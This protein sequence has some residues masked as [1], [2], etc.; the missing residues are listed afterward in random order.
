MANL[1]ALYQDPQFQALT[2]DKKSN[3]IVGIVG[4][5]PD[6]QKLP[7]DR[8][9]YVLNGIMAKGREQWTPKKAPEQESL[10]KNIAGSAATIADQA[11][12]LI[13]GGAQAAGQAFGWAKNALMG[14]P[15]AAQEA[16]AAVSPLD[17][18]QGGY[19]KLVDAALGPG[20]AANSTVGHFFG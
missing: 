3:V 1:S 19:S 8:K 14:K 10:G 6:F 20:T 9:A 2:E 15:Q 12:G 18:L 5:D 4:K 17:H 13:V 16:V 7:D 11:A